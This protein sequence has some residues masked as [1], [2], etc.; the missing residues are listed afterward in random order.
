[1]SDV[2]LCPKFL[3]VMLSFRAI[4]RGGA[5][6]LLVTGGS[7][8]LG[9]TPACGKLHAAAE[10]EVLAVIEAESGYQKDLE[11]AKK[12]TLWEKKLMRW[13]AFRRG[14]VSSFHSLIKLK[15][16]LLD[17]YINHRMKGAVKSMLQPVFKNVEVGYLII[18]NNQE[19]ITRYQQI[20]QRRTEDTAPL[21]N[22]SVITQLRALEERLAPSNQQRQWRDSAAIELHIRGRV[23]KLEAEADFWRREIGRSFHLYQ[24]ARVKFSTITAYITQ[25][26][27]KKTKFYQFIQDI[28]QELGAAHEKYSFTSIKGS[29]QRPALEDITALYFKD[30]G[31][32]AAKFRKQINQERRAVFLY[33][34]SRMSLIERIAEW[35]NKIPVVKD[36][37]IVRLITMIREPDAVINYDPYLS[38]LRT[39]KRH[40]YTA[41]QLL[42]KLKEL[43]S[44]T[45]ETDAMLIRLMRRVDLQEIA[46]EIMT[47]AQVNDPAYYDRLVKAKAVGEKYGK[48]NPVFRPTV[49]D[50]LIVGA[51]ILTPVLFYYM[52][53]DDVQEWLGWSAE[54]KDEILSNFEKLIAL[55]EKKAAEGDVEARSILSN[56]THKP[57]SVE[58]VSQILRAM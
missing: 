1:M 20:L 12:I 36:T 23:K 40:G 15:I 21:F 26:K 53:V 8:G 46:D 24:A 37:D 5:F 41:A 43:N 19:F 18:I 29:G 28:E 56:L 11:Y 10:Q 58:D 14:A 34:V 17:I 22:D 2:L 47:E 45:L 13:Q 31:I 49:A 9:Q 52:I 32:R 3:K 25:N 6:F 33:L 30:H 27:L 16:A 55:L 7:S 50:L 35:L 42:E 39:R 44:S 51:K 4:F 54:N 38:H 57:L 48:V